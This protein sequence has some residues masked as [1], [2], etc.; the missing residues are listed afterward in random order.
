MNQD[1][2]PLSILP[3]DLAPLVRARVPLSD[4]TT[5][6]VGGPARWVCRVTTPQEAVRFHAWVTEAGLP[7]Y[8]LGAGSNV[9]APDAG[10]AGAVFRVDTASFTVRGN[11]VSVG[12]GLA[13]DTIVARCL[14]AG[15]VGLEFASGLPGTLGGAVMGNAGCYGHEIGEFVRRATIMTPDGRIEEIDGGQFGFA[16]RVTALRE[17]GAV[18]LDVVLELAT[19]DVDRARATRRER[20]ADRRAKHPVDLPCAG[21]WFRNL[22]PAGPGQRR[23]AA[24]RL[25]EEAGAKDMREGD[26]RVFARHANIIVNAGRATS[27]QISRLADRMRAAVRERFGIELQEEVRRMAQRERE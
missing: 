14:D 11:R 13:F 2:S 7:V 1:P 23:R 27:A 16:Y 25:L 22:E 24:G 18:L 6:K 10:Y 20:I 15:L 21:S 5:L 8:I 26:A 19:G 3:D 9:L 4:L 12:A 17:T